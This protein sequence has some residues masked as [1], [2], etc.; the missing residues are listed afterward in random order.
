[1]I[2]YLLPLKQKFNC[3][4]AGSV[5]LR[6]DRRVEPG[7]WSK[8]VIEMGDNE[9]RLTVNDRTTSKSIRTRDVSMFMNKIRFIF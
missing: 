7:D 3:L 4:Q 8:I 6:S 5:V 2:T 9:A 1:M